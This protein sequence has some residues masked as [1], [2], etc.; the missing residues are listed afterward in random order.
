[1]SLFVQTGEYLTLPRAPETWVVENLLPTGGILNIY[2]KPKSGK[3]FLALQLSQA[4]STNGTKVL[5]WRIMTH[6]PVCYLQVDTPRGLFCTNYLEQIQADHY[7]MSNL[8][9]ADQEIVPYPFNIMSEGSVWLKHALTLMPHPPVAIVVDTIRE[10]HS[11][12]ENESSVMK[13]VM[14][15]MVA[16]VRSITPNPAIMF[17]SHGRK[18]DPRRL[19][20]DEDIMEGN[21]GSN[22]VA[23]RVD[24]VVRVGNSSKGITR[25]Y[26]KSRTI[27]DTTIRVT[28]N[29]AGFWTP[30]DSEDITL[31]SSFVKGNPTASHNKLAKLLLDHTGYG[32]ISTWTR[33]IDHFL[34]SAPSVAISSENDTSLDEP[35]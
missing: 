2:G 16:S 1:M 5:D 33:K 13:N 12:D 34:S 15:A 17:I 4:I 30:I 23:G 9:I 27:D 28:R 24:G 32:S 3:T 26:Y 22:Y 20:S 14:T 10:I 21:R 25:L 6:G 35:D 29:D 11:G 8:W 19:E 31:I 7:D 18:G